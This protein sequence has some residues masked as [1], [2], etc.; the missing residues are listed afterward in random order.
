MNAL[1]HHNYNNNNNNNNNNNHG[2]YIDMKQKERKSEYMSV[3][4]STNINVVKSGYGSKSN[5]QTKN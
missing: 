3:C 1:D 2:T 4:C 5:S